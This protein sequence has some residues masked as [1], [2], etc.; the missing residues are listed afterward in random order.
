[1]LATLRRQVVKLKTELALRRQQESPLVGQ[2][3]ADPARL[4]AWAGLLPDPWQADLLR[5]E[6]RRVLMLCGRQMGKSTVAAALALKAAL[7]QPRSLVLLLSPTL[8]QSGELFRQKV[9][10][11]YRGLG[12]PVPPAKKP[13]QLELELSNGSRI[14]SLPES[15]EGV[16]GFSSVRLLIVDEASRVSD[17]LY[18]AIRPMLAISRGGLVLLSTPFGR[19]GFFHEEFTGRKT[20][21]RVKATAVQCGRISPEFLAEERQT[22]GE[23]WYG[24]EY[25]CEFRDTIDSFFR[26]EDID[27]AFRP[28]GTALDLGI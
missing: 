17:Q 6:A 19:S 2:L 24:Q 13:T 15:E 7:L 9:L 23:F 27:A 26:Q 14:V 28:G 5:S 18:L 21:H 25:L 10:T 4:L 20:W 22:L 11:L 1:M 3:R 8:R 16:R 12:C